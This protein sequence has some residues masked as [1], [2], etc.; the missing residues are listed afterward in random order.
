MCPHQPPWAAKVAPE[1]QPFALHGERRERALKRRQ[2]FAR[3][4]RGHFV[5]DRNVR[6]GALPILRRQPIAPD[7]GDA[8]RDMAVRWGSRE[9]ASLRTAANTLR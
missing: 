9:Y 2:Q 5:L 4:F 7:S 8:A 3:R 1:V 6:T